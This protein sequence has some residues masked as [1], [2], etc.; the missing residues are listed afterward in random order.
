MLRPVLLILTSI[1]LGLVGL[2]LWRGALDA[3][4]GFELGGAGAGHQL[5]RLIG[6]W[7]FWVGVVVFLGVVVISLD[8]W[9]NE[10]LSQVIPLYSL[11]YVFVALIGKYRLGE[12]VTATRWAG[13]VAIV[14]GV[15]L[16]IRG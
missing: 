15:T 16:L 14:A 13:I 9:S 12:D 4:G 5:V 11:S 2:L 7:Q 8:L 6:R 1:A 3:I 10:E